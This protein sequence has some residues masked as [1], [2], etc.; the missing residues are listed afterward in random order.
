M[1]HLFFLVAWWK[2]GCIL[3]SG[4]DLKKQLEMEDHQ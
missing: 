1:K 3:R 2:F 4:K